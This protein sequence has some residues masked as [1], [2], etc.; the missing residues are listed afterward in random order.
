MMN[1]KLQMQHKKG[2]FKKPPKVK[3]VTPPPVPA[4]DF[5]QHAFKSSVELLYLN[6]IPKVFLT[7]KAYSDMYHYVDIAQQE[8]GWMGS[9]KKV[10]GGFLIQEVFLLD[11]EVDMTNT[12]MSTDGLSALAEELVSDRPDGVD[13][14]NSLL[15]WGHS[16]VRMATSPSGQDE[17]QMSQFR[18]NGCDWFI[19]GILNK[20][21][22]MEFTVFLWDSGVKIVDAP[23]SIYTEVDDSAR[24]TIKREFAEKVRVKVYTPVTH[25]SMPPHLHN[26]GSS[27]G[28]SS[29]MGSDS[30]LT[31]YYRGGGH[32]Y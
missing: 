12:T 16:H 26:A 18:E 4:Q 31:D 29:T 3:Y 2:D 10:P 14:L 32:V 20:L 19:R 28:A 24:E 1:Q 17:T 15:F 13:I 27:F 21:G 25:R 9:V 7:P 8:V 23:W 5:E 6:S 22:R 11:Q 30:D